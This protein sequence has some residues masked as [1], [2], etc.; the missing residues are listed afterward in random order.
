MC[1]CV[2][3]SL[4]YTPPDAA[5]AAGDRAAERAEGA[6]PLWLGAMLALALGGAASTPVSYTHLTLPTKA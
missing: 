2:G 4:S 1:A 6:A 5:G 3:L